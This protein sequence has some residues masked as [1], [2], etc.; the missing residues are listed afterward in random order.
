MS[1]HVESPFTEDQ[2]KS[3]NAYQASKSCHPFTC[4]CGGHTALIA[5]KDGWICPKCD[6]KQ[7]WAH[8]FMADWTW[9]ILEVKWFDKA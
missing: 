9:K 4:I 8:K 7:K 2:V 3:L 5:T 6:Y 1:E